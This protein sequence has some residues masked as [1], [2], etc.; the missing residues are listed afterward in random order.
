MEYLRE[1]VQKGFE[2]ADEDVEAVAATHS[3]LTV[4]IVQGEAILHLADAKR[5]E[6]ASSNLRT[7]FEA[8]CDLMVI[9]NGDK[10]ADG[11]R[12]R[13][14]G[15][16]ELRDFMGGIK[17]DKS[18][19]IEEQLAAYQ[20]SC[21]D[22]V[23]EIEK[24]RAGKRKPNLWSGMGRAQMLRVLAQSF[25]P[26]PKNPDP[27]A[28][29]LQ[30]YKMLSWDT[31]SVVTGVLDVLISEDEAG[32]TRL[33]FGT[34]QPRDETIEFNCSIAYRLLGSAWKKY[35]EVLRLKPRENR[36]TSD[37]IENPNETDRGHE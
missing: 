31:H 30:L 6:A 35:E 3:L 10:N 1:K 13:I 20:L 36:K 16:L 25:P 33:Q 34:R 22:V 12:Y 5:P 37:A 28:L 2:F 4:I 15:L 27:K 14:F 26:S 7:L 19:A 18:G 32:E 8:W 21:P 24:A 17:A 23:V 29:F 11:R 9:L